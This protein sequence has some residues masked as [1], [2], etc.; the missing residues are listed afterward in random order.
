MSAT[1]TVSGRQYPPD[2]AADTVLP[3]TLVVTVTHVVGALTC[4]V[5]LVMPVCA[6]SFMDGTQDRG[7]RAGGS[8][9]GAVPRGTHQLSVQPGPGGHGHESRGSIPAGTTASV[10]HLGRPR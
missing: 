4:L 1:S 10:R 3:L 2:T 5:V 9:S 7:H 8:G 6:L